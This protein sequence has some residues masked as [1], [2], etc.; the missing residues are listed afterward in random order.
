MVRLTVT[1]EATGVFN[2]VKVVFDITIVRVL[3][4]ITNT[5]LLVLRVIR[6][7]NRT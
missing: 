6:T 4:L 7:V 5:K 3:K 1:A 2:G